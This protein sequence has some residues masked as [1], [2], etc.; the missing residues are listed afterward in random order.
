[1]VV[2]DDTLHHLTTLFLLEVILQLA[3]AGEEGFIV[4]IVEVLPSAHTPD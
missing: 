3:N 4:D 1:M 2:A